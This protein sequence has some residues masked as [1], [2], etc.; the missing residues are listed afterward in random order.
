M[1]T[2]LTLT[3][4]SWRHKIRDP[5]TWKPWAK[6]D[7]PGIHSINLD[8]VGG[9]ILGLIGPNGAGKTTL[10]RAICGLTFLEPLAPA[11]NQ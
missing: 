11:D 6:R 10:M 8:I 1:E 9:T 5:S 3:D 2:H 7:G 4:V